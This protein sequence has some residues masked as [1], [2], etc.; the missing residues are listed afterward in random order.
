MSQP[1]APSQPAAVPQ[2]TFRTLIYRRSLGVGI[3]HYHPDCVRWPREAFYEQRETP[4]LYPFCSECDTRTAADYVDKNR[5]AP[6]P[7]H[8]ASE[9]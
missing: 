9:V 8:L 5:A 4:D 7:Y 6:V 2:V 1:T 3:W